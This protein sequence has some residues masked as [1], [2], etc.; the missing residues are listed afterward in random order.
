MSSL[1]IAISDQK[2]AIPNKTQTKLFVLLRGGDGVLMVD[3]IKG[4]KC[5]HK[6]GIRMRNMF[7]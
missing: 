3:D 1:F 4:W 7:I 6:T 2:F 5:V